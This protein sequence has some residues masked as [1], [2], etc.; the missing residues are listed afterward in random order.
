M[1]YYKYLVGIFAYNEDR[2]FFI[3][4]ATGVRLQYALFFSVLK[5]SNILIMIYEFCA[6]SLGYVRFPYYGPVVKIYFVYMTKK[7]V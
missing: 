7:Y 2:C 3:L 4:Q 5:L 6:R 1:Q